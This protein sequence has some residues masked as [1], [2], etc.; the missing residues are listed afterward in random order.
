MIVG[1]LDQRRYRSSR[2]VEQRQVASVD[3]KHFE[4]GTQGV[5]R[6]GHMAVEPL[7]ELIDKCLHSF[8]EVRSL[9]RHGEDVL[10]PD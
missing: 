5:I 3:G 6:H 8:E 7:A 2:P 9:N 10:D 4:D 1:A